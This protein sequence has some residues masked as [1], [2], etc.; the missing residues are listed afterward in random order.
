MNKQEAKHDGRNEL[1]AISGALLPDPGSLCPEGFVPTPIWVVKA[2]T[3]CWG[4][5]REEAGVF[6]GSGLFPQ[7]LPISGISGTLKC[8][9]ESWS[10]YLTTKL[11]LGS[12]RESGWGMVFF[13]LSQNDCILLGSGRIYHLPH[14]PSCLIL[15]GDSDPGSELWAQRINASD[16]LA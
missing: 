1:Q 9:T 3:D 14:L 11:S 13:H 15:P 5:N 12:Q 2:V 16:S 4:E 7:Q 8:F 10:F 6:R